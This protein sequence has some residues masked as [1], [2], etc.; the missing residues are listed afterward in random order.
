MMGCVSKSIEST[1]L[2]KEQAGK[3]RLRP[4]SA[5]GPGATNLIP[6]AH[7]CYAI[8]LR[9]PPRVDEDAELV[10]EDRKSVGVLVKEGEVVVVRV[11][12][13]KVKGSKQL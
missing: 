7:F 2:M 4:V 8:A 12:E 9:M 1:L 5:G 6:R 11:S 13:P 3:V 10:V